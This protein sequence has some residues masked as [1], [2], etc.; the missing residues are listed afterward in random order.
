MT[1]N[2]GAFQLPLRL[3]STDE[4]HRRGLT[5][6]EDGLAQWPRVPCASV[7][8]RVL[9]AAERSEATRVLEYSGG[10]FDSSRSKPLPHEVPQF[11]RLVQRAPQ[12]GLEAVQ[13]EALQMG[14]DVQVATHIQPP[15]PS[16]SHALAATPHCNLA[17]SPPTHPHFRLTLIPTLILVSASA[18]PRPSTPP[19]PYPL[20]ILTLSSPYPHPISTAPRLTPPL[21]PPAEY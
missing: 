10:G 17:T 19:S 18:E 14:Q 20:P 12:S 4:A 8:V 9:S 16:H 21:L 5:P 13:A 15:Q 11:R 2:R 7:L 1:L 6:S 3:N